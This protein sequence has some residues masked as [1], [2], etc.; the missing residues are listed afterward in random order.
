MG[1]DK[2][3]KKEDKES[4]IIIEPNDGGSGDKKPRNKEAAEAA[5]L[6]TELLRAPASKQEGLLN[7]LRDGKGIEYTDA[8][9]NAIPSLKGAIKEKAR[10]ALAARMTRM[11]LKTLKQKLQDEQL[12]VRLA[13]ALACGRKNAKGLTPDLI[14]LLADTESQVASAAHKT[15]KKL[16]GEDFGPKAEANST[17][18]KAAIARWNAWWKKKNGE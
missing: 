17:E 1:K 5:R 14:G 18:R 4:K 3:K 7:D 12:E 10:L 2:K 15:L 6:R 9:A 16:T 11:S 13:A 8:L